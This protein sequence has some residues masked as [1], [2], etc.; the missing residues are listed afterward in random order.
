VGPTCTPAPL[1]APDPRRVV[2]GGQRALDTVRVRSLLTRPARG[3]VSPPAAQRRLS[4]RRQG[5]ERGEEVWLLGAHGGAAVSSLLLAGVPALDACRS[6]PAGGWV[7]LVAR[8]SSRGLRSARDAAR[9]HASDTAG[10]G[11]SL[12]GLVLVADA[13]GSLPASLAA[14]ADLVAGA[15]ARVYE[16]PWLEEWR[17]CPDGEALPA[18]P[19]VRRLTDDLRTLL[20]Q[21]TAEG[22]A[23]WA[24]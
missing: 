12:V 4:L 8:T 5:A 1:L 9:Q 7:L 2:T 6:W 19:E 20:P 17:Q 16:V 13:P 21:A 14:F 15:F 10:A 11:C 22:A 3:L 18:P 24:S 23:A